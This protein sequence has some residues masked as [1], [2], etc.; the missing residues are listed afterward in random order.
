MPAASSSAHLYA[1]WLHTQNAGSAAYLSTSPHTINKASQPNTH[2]HT[3]DFCHSFSGPD[4]QSGPKL[5][6]HST[7]REE[8][9]E[10]ESERCWLEKR[11]DFGSSWK[12]AMSQKSYLK[13][14]ESGIKYKTGG[15]VIKID[16]A[17]SRAVM[18]AVYLADNKHMV[19]KQM[20]AERTRIVMCLLQILDGTATPE[21]LDFWQADKGKVRETWKGRWEREQTPDSERKGED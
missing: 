16:H 15:H 8:K 7:G 9:K 12:S 5:N 20:T 19:R 14:I 6:E 4:R 3:G 1:L 10:R 11:E 2:S 17:S 21:V 13:M 18:S